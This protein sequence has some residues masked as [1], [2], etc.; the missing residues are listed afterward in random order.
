MSTTI[1][2]HSEYECTV[3]HIALD[4][5]RISYGGLSCLSCRAFFRRMCQKVNIAECKER[6]D[7][8][9]S[10]IDRVSCPPCRFQKCV[11][12]GMKSELIGNQGKNKRKEVK[13]KLKP[14]S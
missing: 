7:C 10:F 14:N 4:R 5:I 3:C 13:P 11:S 8:R 6:R 12:A 1:L 2:T 9:V